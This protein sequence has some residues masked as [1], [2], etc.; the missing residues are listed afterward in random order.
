VLI[1]LYKIETSV[2]SV[3]VTKTVIGRIVIRTA[4]KFNDNLK[5]SNQKGKVIKLAKKIG[6]GDAAIN[7]LDIT[8][9]S[10]GLDI[11]IFVVMNFGTSIGNITNEFIEE[12]YTKVQEITGIK[13]NSVAVIVAGMLANKQVARRNIEVKR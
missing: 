13:P 11:R 2:G 6:G 4:Q 3:S 1:L 7:N 9:G 5:I 10:N 8:M 12:V